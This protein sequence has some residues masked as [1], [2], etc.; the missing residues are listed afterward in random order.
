MPTPDAVI[1]AEIDRLA[2]GRG[3]SGVSLL[4]IMVVVAIIGAVI[5]VTMPSMERLFENQRIKGAARAGADLLLLA[6]S[7]AI[8]TGT[9]HVVFFGVDPDGTTMTD[10]NGG[11]APLLV[12]ND[13]VTQNCRIDANELTEA[14]VADGDEISWGSVL[15]TGK[16]TSDTGGET[17]PSFTPPSAPPPSGSTYKDP[18]GTGRMDWVMFRPDGMPVAFDG[19]SGDCGNVGPAGQGGGAIY[20]TNGKRDYSVVI[21]PLGNVRVHV[22]QPNANSWSS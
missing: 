11:F 18:N 10:P 9:P 12:L 17:L 5:A 15:A 22:W 21:S 1:R 4:E 3:A 16:V 20:I 6:R 8:R 14:M 7:E 13:S 19:D 2:R